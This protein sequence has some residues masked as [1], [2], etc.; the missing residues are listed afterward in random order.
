MEQ[1][2]LEAKNL[3]VGYVSNARPAVAG[4]DFTLGEGETL[5]L[6]GQSGCGK[7]SVVSV[8]YTHLTLPTN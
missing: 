5:C 8:S 3:T 4:L 6:H 7:S 1:T 2:I